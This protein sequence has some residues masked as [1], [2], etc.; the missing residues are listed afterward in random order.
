MDW[1]DYYTENAGSISSAEIQT[2]MDAIVNLWIQCANFEVSLHQFKKAVDVYD[3]ALIDP[4]CSKALAIFRAYASFC[5]DRKKPG[6]A[7]NVYIKG[8]CA[9]LSE[10]DNEALW[11][12]FLDL[13]HSVN[14]SANLTIE[15]LY[16]AVR[17]QDGVDEALLAVPA[18]VQRSETDAADVDISIDE[19]DANEAKEEEDEAVQV[20]GTVST[21]TEEAPAE[22]SQS[23]T[24]PTAMDTEQPPSQGSAQQQSPA[25]AAEPS[26]AP[27]ERRY[28]EL[29]GLDDVSGYSPEQLIRTF[30]AR[31]PM[32]FTSLQKVGQ[33]VFLYFSLGLLCVITQPTGIECLLASY[34]TLPP[35]RDCIIWSSFQLP[36]VFLLVFLSKRS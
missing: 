21:A 17:S 18:G 13:M 29:D 14:K 6:N 11:K 26:A 28:A 3:R 30:T 36:P 24:T 12:D 16:E 34:P 1:S 10:P 9:G 31:P 7:Q 27:V 22:R 15:Q 5:L 2:V 20:D 4:I 33:I 8:L 25:A 32:L 23:A 19:I 35:I